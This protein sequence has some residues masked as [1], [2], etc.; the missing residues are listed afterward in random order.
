MT[1]VMPVGID[2]ASRRKAAERELRELGPVNLLAEAELTELS[3]RNAFL[4]GQLPIEH[5]NIIGEGVCHDVAGGE[6]A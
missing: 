6:T 3:E 4:E 1:L 5:V 2:P